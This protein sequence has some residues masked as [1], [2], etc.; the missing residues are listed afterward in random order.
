MVYSDREEIVSINSPCR[1]H[2][3]DFAFFGCFFLF[4]LFFV[5]WLFVVNT[6]NVHELVFASLTKV[7]EM[8]PPPV[9]I[10]GTF[11]FFFPYFFFCSMGASNVRRDGILLSRFLE[12]APEAWKWRRERASTNAVRGSRR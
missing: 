6:L 5:I 10:S 11:L 8:G 4:L 3:F 2:F 7:L 1:P 9:C 12:V